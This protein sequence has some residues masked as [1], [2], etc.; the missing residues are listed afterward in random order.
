VPV[1]PPPASV[2]FLPLLGP[3]LLDDVA[4]FFVAALVAI[5]FNAEGQ[6]WLATLLGD[7]R[8]DKSERLHFNVFLHLDPLGTL[9]FFL[10][11]IGWPRWVPIDA[12]RF[13]EPG[14]YRIVSRL[15]GPLANLMLAAISASVVFVLERYGAVDRVFT[16][17]T[18]V[19]V[20]VA[21]YTLIPIPPLAAAGILPWFRSGGRL[22]AAARY[23]GGTAV[24]LLLC[25]ERY[26]GFR[27]ITPFLDEAVRAI[28]AYLLA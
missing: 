22:S 2:P 3:H 24:L 18:S 9:A 12:D 20:A 5:L 4:G 13:S 1:N 28:V 11:G 14:T 21:I 16:M 10:T 6:G 23:G 26:T 27:L 8:T 25:A 19:N 7:A 17:V 15:G